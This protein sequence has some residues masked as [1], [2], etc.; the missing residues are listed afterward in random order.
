VLELLAALALFIGPTPPTGPTIAWGD[1]THAWAGGGAG[2]LASR[3][4]GAT[5][6]Q[7]TRAPA[8]QLAA[9]DARHAWALSAQGVTIR[10]TDGVHW[11]SLGVQHLM[12]LSFIDA[13]HGFSLE[14]DDFLMRTT[15]GGVTWTPTGGPSRLQSICFSTAS[16]GWVA[17]NGTIWTTHDAGAHWR[18]VTVMRM[19]QGFPLPELSCRGSDLWLVLHEGAA[20]G[21]EGYD[22]YRSRDAGVH[23]TKVYASPFEQNVPHVSNYSG[24]VVAL[25]DA[26]AVL[27]GSCAPC[28]GYGT[29]TIV[30][31]QIKTTL[32]GVLPGP[33]AFGDPLRG[34]LVLTSARTGGLP[35]VW[36]TVD[37]GRRWTRV[38]TSSRLKP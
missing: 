31:G 32:S 20:A 38:L 24:P 2:I 36:R 28:G 17:R 9:T 26:D 34:L 3:D 13:R 30:H 29:V 4:G 11:R 27:E 35:S 14:R 7:Q 1:A 21:T 16:I 15:D 25:G 33:M 23:W 8:L 10:T 18:A 5:W 19:R 12:R 37:G 22:I 6:R